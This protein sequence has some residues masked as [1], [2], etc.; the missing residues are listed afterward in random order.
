MEM[1]LREACNFSQFGELHRAV[2]IPPKIVN[3]LVDSAGVFAVGPGLC[4]WHG[5]RRLYRTNHPVKGEQFYVCRAGGGPA[6][7]GRIRLCT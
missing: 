5:F 2:Q 7:T 3:Y 4:A 1:E 6:E